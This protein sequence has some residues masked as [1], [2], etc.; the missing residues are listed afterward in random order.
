MGFDLYRETEEDNDYFRWNIW[1]WPPIM[2]LAELYGWQPMGCVIESWVDDEGITHDE[3]ECGYSSND[4][5]TVCEEDAMNWAEA[6]ELALSDLRKEPTVKEGS[7]STTID[8]EF[9]SDRN[10]IHSKDAETLKREFNTAS[11]Q[12]YLE[13]Y[14]AFL[15]KGSFKIY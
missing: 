8:D 10:L 6:L 2:F 5:Q 14:I 15:K 12:E 4:G 9:W 11:E 7:K 1:G 13:M 3:T